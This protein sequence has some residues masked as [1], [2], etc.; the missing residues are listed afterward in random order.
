MQESWGWEILKQEWNQLREHP[1][2]AFTLTLP[3]GNYFPCISRIAGSAKLDRF[4]FLSVLC[5]ARTVMLCV[6]PGRQLSISYLLTPHSDMRKQTGKVKVR[7]MTRWGSLK[8]ETKT[9]PR[10]TSDGKNEP[11]CST[12]ADHCPVSLHI[13]AA[14]ANF[15]V[16][17]AVQYGISFRPFWFS[18][19]GSVP[20]QLFEPL[21]R[22]CRPGCENYRR[23]WCCMSTALRYLKHQHCFHHKSKTKLWGKLTL[24]QT[25]SI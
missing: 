23:P 7:E 3:R 14:S 12:P 15:A 24:S 25:K 6:N 16:F 21:Q 8:R 17:I 18:S 5:G 22:P 9:K 4:S 11:R 10:K 2:Q 13:T 19:P 1:Q 20:S